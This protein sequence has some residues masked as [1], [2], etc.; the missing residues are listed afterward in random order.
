MTTL[1]ILGN[2]KQE[3]LS[4]AQDCCGNSELQQALLCSVVQTNLTKATFFFF[5]YYFL[6]KTAISFDLFLSPQISGEQCATKCMRYL[7][8]SEYCCDIS[9][10]SETSSFSASFLGAHTGQIIRC[11]DVTRLT[12]LVFSATSSPVSH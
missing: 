9:P 3:S 2:N 4:V 1:R 5:Y 6:T 12:R 11:Q 10:F 8:Q 7:Y